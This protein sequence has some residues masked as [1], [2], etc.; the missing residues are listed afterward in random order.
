MA[1]DV[2]F[3]ESSSEWWVPVRDDEA[4]SLSEEERAVHEDGFTIDAPLAHWEP[5]PVR[6]YLRQIGRARLLTREQEGEIGRRIEVARRSL[7]Q[8]LTTIPIAARHLVELSEG[9]CTPA[10][11]EHLVDRIESILLDEP[12]KLALLDRIMRELAVLRDAFRRLDAEPQAIRGPRARALEQEVGL[13]RRAFEQRLTRATEADAALSR[14]KQDLMEANLRLV[15]SVAKRYI[16]RGLPFLDLIQEGNLGLIKAVERF[17][18]RRG[19]KFSTYATWWIR[20]SV[21]RA[22]AD[23]ARTIRLPVHL[24]DALN[25]LLRAQ[26]RLHEELNRQPTPYEL[27]DRLEM[28]VEKVEGLLRARLTPFSLD[29]PL[30]DDLSLGDTLKSQGPSPEHETLSADRRRAVQ[31]HLTV[32]S[33][34]ERDILRRRYGLML[35]RE[36]TLDEIGVALSISR[37]RVR[38]IEKAAM[39]KLRRA[40]HVATGETAVRRS[41]GGSR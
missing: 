17:Q 27:A 15:V 20:Q 8:V 5:D 38:Q 33:D 22:I 34:R 19:F 6:T 30:G 26:A 32:L 13:R 39:K 3:P 11:V 7:L 37:E 35:E 14:A 16:G 40:M 12:L 23:S 31:K 2:S 18:Y 24:F 4:G 36:Q 9:A 25:Q 29:L 21:Q 1:P 41:A 28:P 10:Q